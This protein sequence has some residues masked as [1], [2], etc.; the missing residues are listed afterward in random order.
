MDDQQGIKTAIERNVKAVSLRPGV[1]Q[2][3]ARTVAT[4]EPGLACKVTDGPY[5]LSVG[6]TEKYGGAGGSPNPGVLGR[7]AVA[8]CLT[9]GLSMWAARMGIPLERLEVTVEADYDV[10]GELGVVDEIRPGY[11]AMRYHILVESPAPEEEVRAWLDVGTR[12]S[13][14]LDNLAN[15]M[16][17]SGTIDVRRTEA[18]R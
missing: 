2:G 14:W 5:T 16:P 1:G 9:I 7:G 4:L 17:L 10:R 18:A 6:M 15:P 12:T 11:L 13:S 3:T 8:S